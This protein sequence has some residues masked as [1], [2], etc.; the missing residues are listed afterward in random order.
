MSL[1]E[2]GKSSPLV[3]QREEAIQEL[4][5]PNSHA[6]SSRAVWRGRCLLKMGRLSPF[7]G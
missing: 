6:G 3:T 7:T 1:V 5:F 2:A 4:L